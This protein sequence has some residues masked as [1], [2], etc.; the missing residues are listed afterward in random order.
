MCDT[1]IARI[2]GCRS[3]T[4][5]RTS[6]YEGQHQQGDVHP[7]LIAN[8]KYVDKYGVEGLASWFGQRQG[9]GALEKG[10]LRFSIV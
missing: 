3:A 9:A 2:I 8:Y 10:D 6:L 4:P 7:C 1:P 5:L